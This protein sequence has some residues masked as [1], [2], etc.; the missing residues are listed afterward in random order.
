MTSRAGSNNDEQPE[1]ASKPA[2]PATKRN[3]FSELMSPKHKQSKP[4]ISTHIGKHS[5]PGDPR[6][7]LL[8]YILEPANYPSD[9]VILY[10]DKA[11]LVRDAFPKATVHLLLLPR[12]PLKRDLNPRDALDDQEFL[13]M[14]RKEATE[15]VKLA[16]SEL[17][18]LIAPYSESCKARIAAMESEDPP[19]ELPPGRDFSKEFKV[20][21]HA[22]PSMNQLHIH[23][24]S[25]DMHSDRLKHRKHYNSF[26]TDFFI[27]LEDFPLAQDD[28]RRQTSYQ[29]ANLSKEYKCWRCG[30]MFGNKFTQLKA[31]LEEEFK[32]WRRE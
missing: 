11:V 18:R 32:T 12:D 20:G 5:N 7:G 26:N 31:H 19:D 17:S 3:A 13:D 1:E 6:N 27:P 29:N 4:Q 30:K 25:R 9:I 10:N 8:A 16:A 14:V 21:I 2:A 24:I 15:A 22:H 23:I 28:A